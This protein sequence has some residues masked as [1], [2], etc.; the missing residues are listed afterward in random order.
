MVREAIMTSF[1][2]THK[3]ELVLASGWA[4]SAIC[5]SMPP[6]PDK[7]GYLLTWAHNFLQAAAGNIN[8][9]RS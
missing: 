8:K 2:L 6:L 7:A 5:S 9:I 3:A 4:F 1:L